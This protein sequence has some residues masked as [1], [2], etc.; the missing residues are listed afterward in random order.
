A[1]VPHPFTPD[2]ERLQIVF[3]RLRTLGAEC[4][5]VFL[6]TALV[7]MTLDLHAR[8]TVRLQPVSVGM[9][10]LAVLRT[11]RIVVV[12][13]M[14]IAERPLAAAPVCPFLQLPER[15]SAKTLLADCTRPARPAGA[16]EAFARLL[17]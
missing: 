16:G 14:N 12:V 13:E 10:N 3:C 8:A 2:A 7:A 6:R 17:L 1:H 11:H 5:I 15:T 4:D 9:Q